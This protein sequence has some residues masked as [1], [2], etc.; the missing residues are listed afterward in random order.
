MI[1][2]VDR[3][4][5]IIRCLLCLLL[6]VPAYALADL[7]LTGGTTTTLDGV[8]LSENIM[9]DAGIETINTDETIDNHLGPRGID[10]NRRGNT[11]LI[12]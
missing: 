3:I 2:P 10:G 12:R 6:L 11:D 8:T 4:G 7:T 1:N 9:L 5:S